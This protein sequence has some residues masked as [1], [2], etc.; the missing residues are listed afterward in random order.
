M[1]SFKVVKT[2]GIARI[3]DGRAHPAGVRIAANL[4][5]ARQQNRLNLAGDVGEPTTRQQV[6]TLA[7]LNP[8]REGAL[9]NVPDAPLDCIRACNCYSGNASWP[10]T[11]KCPLALGAAVSGWPPPMLTVYSPGAMIGLP[12][13]VTIPRARSFNSK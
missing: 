12:S 4:S 9:G 3:K 5:P 13:S 1:F 6:L 8:S 7:L 11:R 10:S 2:T